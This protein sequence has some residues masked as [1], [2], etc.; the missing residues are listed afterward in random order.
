MNRYL[1]EGMALHTPENMDYISTQGLSRAMAENRI[2]E[3][4]AIIC[5]TGH[6]LNVKLGDTIG[7]I[8]RD[9]AAIGISEG[10][11]RDIAIISRVGKPVCFK[12]QRT[13]PEILLS[14]RDAQEEAL[15]W[16]LENLTPGD[17][18]P[19]VVTHTAAFG[20]FVDI[21][22]GITGL[23][24]IENLSVSR[25]A[26][27]SDRVYPGQRIYAAVLTID[28]D[29]R[30]IT[31]THRELLGTWQENASMFNPGETVP[32]IVRG[33]K[34]YG[35]FVELSPNLSGLAE[36]RDD[37]H[38]GDHVSVYIKSVIPEK[39]KIKLVIIDKTAPPSIRP[40]LKYFITDGSIRTWNYC[41]VESGR[42]LPG[43]VFY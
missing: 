39:M 26:H 42:S 27:S 7:V 8:P 4:P 17:V 18:I 32:G 14:R 11:T 9:M 20:A 36:Y 33:K 16:F 34:D 31:L 41:T 5:T 6:D 21:G 13:E 15:N 25:I 40:P 28:R 35:L 22:C 37:I 43:T 38:E 29:T 24:G 3:A 19:C 1:P 23:I 10:V 2:I 30:R 12:V